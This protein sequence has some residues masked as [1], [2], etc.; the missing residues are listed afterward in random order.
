MLY[1]GDK[2]SHSNYPAIAISAILKLAKV[3]LISMMHRQMGKKSRIN[4]LITSGCKMTIRNNKW[5][6]L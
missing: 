5:S 4:R 1:K 3:A 6:R 2:G